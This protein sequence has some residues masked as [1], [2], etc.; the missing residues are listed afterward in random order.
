MNIKFINHNHKRGFDTWSVGT[1]DSR[2]C[3]L[4][5]LQLSKFM[6]LNWTSGGAFL[7]C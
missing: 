6:Y 7:E 4:A 2:Q 5:R 3:L 1:G